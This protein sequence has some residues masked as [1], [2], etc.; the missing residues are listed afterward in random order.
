MWFM[1][2]GKE[3]PP[4]QS[5]EF[6]RKN[7]QRRFPSYISVTRERDGIWYRSSSPSVNSVSCEVRHGCD[8]V[9]M[10]DSL[11]KSHFCSDSDQVY[12]RGRRPPMK[13]RSALLAFF[14]KHTSTNEIRPT[15]YLNYILLKKCLVVSLL[16]FLPY[17]LLNSQRTILFSSQPHFARGSRPGDWKALESMGL[18]CSLLYSSKHHSRGF[19]FSWIF[20]RCKSVM[21]LEWMA[22]CLLTHTSHPRVRFSPHLNGPERERVSSWMSEAF[23][24]CKNIRRADHLVQHPALNGPPLLVLLKAVFSAMPITMA[25]I[26]CTDGWDERLGF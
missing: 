8:G 21:F 23:L 5:S 12:S 10:W 7:T 26:R 2:C 6:V 3:P 1:V 13:T 14:C 22:R 11:W 19:L 20:P 9:L 24:G 25:F 18:S 4:P 17:I 16:D 15:S